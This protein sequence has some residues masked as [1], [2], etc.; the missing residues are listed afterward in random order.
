LAKPDEG[1]LGKDEWSALEKRTAQ[2]GKKVDIQYLTALK[3][4]HHR[5]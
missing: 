1:A 4:I 3:Y 5:I 2:F